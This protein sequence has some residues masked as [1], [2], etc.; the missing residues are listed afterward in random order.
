MPLESSKSRN[1]I[2]IDYLSQLNVKLK[3]DRHSLIYIL[4]DE[5]SKLH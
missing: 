1:V 2:L 5:N 3:V 4:V